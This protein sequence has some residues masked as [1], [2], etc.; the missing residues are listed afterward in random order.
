MSGMPL[1]AIAALIIILLPIVILEWERYRVPD[2]LYLLLAGS[3]VLFT[4]LQIGL[5]A[6]VFAALTSSLC[7]LL[8]GG[9][10][11]YMRRTWK[12]RLLSG[13]QIKLLAAGS[14]WLGPVGAVLMLAVAV[15]LFI[16]SVLIL[17]IRKK[18]VLRPDSEAIAAIAI[19]VIK[20]HQGLATF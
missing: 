20:V 17:R 7:V 10:V 13:G 19:L 18:A 4:L 14:A 9:G 1:I 15:L 16:L 11:A 2:W 8:I 12:L 5:S 3:G 6:A